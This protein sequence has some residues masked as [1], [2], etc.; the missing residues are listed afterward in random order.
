MEQHAKKQKWSTQGTTMVCYFNSSEGLSSSAIS[1]AK[2]VDAAIDEIW[3]PNIVARYMHW[4]TGKET[5][6]E[7]P[8]RE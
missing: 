7:N 2:D 3:K 8:Y 6:D 4:P 5:F 1:L